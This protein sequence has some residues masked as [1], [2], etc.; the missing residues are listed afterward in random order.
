MSGGGQERG[1]RSGTLAPHQIVGMG[2][3]CRIYLEEG[4]YDY[5]HI[6]RLSTK[7]TQG[8]MNE[9]GHV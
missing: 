7:L 9:I 4:N 5:S 1:F 2:E 3:A 6:K 8:I